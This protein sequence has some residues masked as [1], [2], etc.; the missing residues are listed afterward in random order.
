[1]LGRIVIDDLRPRTPGSDHPAKAVIG[2][3]VR[4]SADVFRD[5]HAI[6]AARVLWRAEADSKWTD[7]P[8]HE[9]GN[10]RWEGVLEPAA[11]GLHTF[12][13][14]AWTD[15]FSTWRRD[16][17]VKHGAGQNVSVEITEGAQLLSELAPRVPRSDRSVVRAAAVALADP[18]LPIGERLAAALDASVALVLA[19]VPER[20]DLTRSRPQRLWVDRERALFGA[21]YELF[22]RS[23]GGLRQ[24]ADDRLGAVAEM[25]F[26]VVYLP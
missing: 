8:M 13:V 25:G 23:E 24:T 14:E 20:A 10:D 3:A 4:V 19:G 18:A 5:G 2:E 26:D 12:A 9:V 17:A 11:L 1:M 15:R 6:L 16:V 7:A 22:P 21:W